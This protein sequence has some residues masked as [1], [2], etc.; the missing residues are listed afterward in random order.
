VTVRATQWGRPRGVVAT[1]IVVTAATLV[2]AT[3]GTAAPPAQR[4][5]DSAHVCRL[6]A[7]RATLPPTALRGLI[8]HLSQYPDVSLATPTQR[9]AA[10]RLLA[11]IREVAKRYADPHAAERA[12]YSTR[13]VTRR[14]GDTSPHYL[15]AERLRERKTGPAF[16]PLRPKALIFVNQPGR[17]LRLV[18]AMYSMKRGQLGPSPGGP[19]TRWHSHTVCSDGGKRG[20]KPRPNGTCPRGMRLYQ[21]SEMMHVWFTRDLR[22]AFAIGAPEP[23]L[24]RAGLVVGR[25]CSRA[26]AR[27]VM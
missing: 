1:A 27:R 6:P 19:I 21:G 4:A 26:G 9:V 16:D 12:R 7:G 17:P 2:I 18:G 10:R 14:P 22:S 13:T 11:R 5:L 20:R 24:C 3:R 23:E 15:H 25:W 8:G